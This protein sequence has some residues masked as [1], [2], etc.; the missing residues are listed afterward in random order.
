MNCPHCGRDTDEPTPDQVIERFYRHRLQGGN[1]SLR[2]IASD[3]PYSYDYLRKVK[4]QYD[5][6]GKW[7]ARSELPPRFGY[8]CVRKKVAL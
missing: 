6:D 8:A 2:Q 1:L 3:A 4:R 7:G 5:A